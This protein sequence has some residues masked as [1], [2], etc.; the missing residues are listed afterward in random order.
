MEITTLVEVTNKGTPTTAVRWSSVVGEAAGM[1]RPNVGL[2]YTDEGY[3]EVDA[4]HQHSRKVD[5]R[6]QSRRS[7]GPTT[8]VVTGESQLGCIS[9]AQYKEECCL[10]DEK[11]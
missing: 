7:D 3:R 9:A 11:R 10:V 8:V 4:E 1:A 5:Q 2:Q 6:R